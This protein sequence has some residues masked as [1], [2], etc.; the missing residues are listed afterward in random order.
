MP[1]KSSFGGDHRR[2]RSRCGLCGYVAPEGLRRTDHSGRGRGTR[3]GGSPES[4]ER[5][6]AGTASDDWIPLRTREYYDSIQVEL[7]TG[8]AAV[9]VDPAAREAVLRSGR[10]LPYEALLLATGA[11]PRSLSTDGA[12]LPHVHRLRTL[13]DSKAIIEG[14]QKAMRCVVIG[15]SF[16]G[17][18]VAASLR[19][20]GL[21]VTVIGREA[22]PLEKVLGPEL[23]RFIQ[24]LHEQQGVRFVMRTTPQ[25]IH[26]DRV[27]LSNGQ[28]IEADLVVMGTGVSPR[29]A[30][31]EDAGL[32]VEDG[33]V[34]DERLMS[35]VADI[36]AA[37][38]I[39]RATP[40]RYP[41]S[42]R[43]LSTGLWRSVRARRW[44]ER[45]W[46]WER[47][48]GMCLSSGANT[49]TW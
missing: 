47:P 2:A 25:T 15:S 37:G 23:G 5:L 20:R 6:L 39:A 32:V 30:L 29:T 12:G 27:A 28:S 38:D 36:W 41:A 3:S 22:I 42:L 13:A 40:T 45:C 43:G 21:D 19:H 24:A 35:S 49:M 10:K 26:A 44:R 16:I 1:A 9:R 17:L 11:E 48:S 7:I 18:E 34:V 33:V 31:A 14:A 8:D 4:L 46:V